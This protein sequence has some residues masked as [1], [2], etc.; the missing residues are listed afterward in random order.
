MSE[1]EKKLLSKISIDEA[2]EHV[3]R[4]STLDKTSGTEGERKAHEYVRMK[5]E[6]YGVPYEA[7][8]FDS[9]ISHPKE[10]SI[11][12]V[13]PESLMVECITHSFSKSTPN[14][15]LEAELVHVPVS[16]SS[17]FTGLG[18]LVEQYEKIGVEGKI[19][20]MYGVAS[21]AVVWAAQRA[22]AIGQV[23]ICGGDILHEMIVTTVWGTP[24]PEAAERIPKITAVSIKRTDGGRL[25]GLCDKE[26]VKIR[27]KARTDTRW[28]RIPFTFAEIWG[29]E[30]PEKF[31]LVH[32][33]M[34]SWYVG[35]TDNCTGNAALLEL[36]RLLHDNRQGLKRSVKIAWWS[37]HSTGRYSSSTWYADNMYYDLDRNCFLSMNIDSPGVRGATELGGGGLMGTMDFINKAAKDATGIEE[38]EK[39]AYYMR[40]GD[41]SFYGIGIP[42]VAVRAYIPDGSPHK[43]RWIGGS[44]GAWW[45][46]SAFDTLDKGD[47]DHLLR[48]M[49][50]E[51]LA[52]YRSCNSHV[53]PYNFAEVAAMYEETTVDIQTKTASGTFN[54]NPV[55]DTIREMKI[56]SEELNKRLENFSGNPQALNDLLVE[57]TR[58]LT[59]TYYTQT[60]PFDQ[61][62]AYGIPHLPTLQRASRLAT[63]DHESDE[64][65]FL[66][67]RM[68]RE[69]N[70]VC[71]AIESVTKLIER[72]ISVSS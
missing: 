21:P 53:L 16:P 63:L 29:Y 72:A 22:G 26:E 39:K 31:M 48:D 28:R 69:R 47:K 56:K 57:A 2:W 32:G 55:L 35:T 11:R 27:L 42:S 64:V 30:R 25:V 20:L 15:G 61:D 33:H 34:D 41:Q 45:W 50:M 9:L 62:P 68:I 65:R 37:G 7:Y 19:T 10:A 6:E 38:V 23:H 54:L 12:I 1:A 70:R 14:E 58:I 3:E 59:S 46:H 4:L 18:D 66:Q 5:L 60:G 24:T 67:T 44:G 36:A 71:N 43:G 51:A 40:A 13:S 8:G 49:R 17:L 52:I